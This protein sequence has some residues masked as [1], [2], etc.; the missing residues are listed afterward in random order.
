MI[1]K[2]NKFGQKKAQCPFW[3]ARHIPGNHFQSIQTILADAVHTPGGRFLGIW[4]LSQVFNN[5]QLYGLL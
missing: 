1:F 2:E 5:N 3:S 4:G